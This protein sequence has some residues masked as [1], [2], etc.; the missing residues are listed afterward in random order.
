MFNPI[1]IGNNSNQRKD[2]ICQWSKCVFASD[3]FEEFYKHVSTH[4]I[5]CMKNNI[6][7]VSDEMTKSI[8]PLRTAKVDNCDSSSKNKKFDINKSKQDV[9]GRNVHWNNV[10]NSMAHV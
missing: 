4:A 10:G 1:Y 6:P 3:N 2:Y 8:T 5:K 9:G 7:I